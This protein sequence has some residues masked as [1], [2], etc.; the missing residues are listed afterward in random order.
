MNKD[1]KIQIYKYLKKIMEQKKQ[2]SDYI[3]YYDL[4]DLDKTMDIEQIKEKLNDKKLRVLFHPDQLAFIE[5]NFKDVYNDSINYYN[6]ARDTLCDLSS[7]QEYDKFIEEQNKYKITKEDIK[8]LEEAIETT[9]YKYGFYQGFY[10][11]K[12]AAFND[13]NFIT[14]EKKCRSKLQM[15]GS[16]KIQKILYDN[17]SNLMEK[18]VDN[19]IMDYYA[20]IINKTGLNQKKDSFYRAC[21]ETTMKYDLNGINQT[22]QAVKI[23]VN[24]P[25]R[26]DVF[27]NQHLAR[28]ELM[29]NGIKPL[30][31]VIL[32]GAKMHGLRSKNEANSYANYNK[33]SISKQ[34]SDFTSVINQEARRIQQQN[35]K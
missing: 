26:Y 21:L 3:D 23:F 17:R 10:A 9:I 11:L 15:M 5:D 31:A 1:T 4:F 33:Q 8:S 27:T 32:M 25:N 19:V 2:H 22:A 35:A 6:S 28:Q 12:Q 14:A 13:F 24:N 30:D 34:I 16:D 20:K 7:K 29:E 18:E